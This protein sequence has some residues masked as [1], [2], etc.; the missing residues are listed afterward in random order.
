VELYLG[1]GVLLLE[2]MIKTYDTS[3]L[4]SLPAGQSSLMIYTIGPVVYICIF[5]TQPAAIKIE[6]RELSEVIG[7]LFKQVG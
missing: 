4:S 5:A 1:N 3:L 7:F 6:S 2:Q